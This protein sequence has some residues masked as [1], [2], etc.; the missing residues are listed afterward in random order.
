M[1]VLEALTLLRFLDQTGS[2]SLALLHGPLIN[3]FVQYDDEEP[4]FLPRMSPAFLKERL[5]ISK[6]M[7]ASVVREFPE[8]MLWCHFMSTYCYAINRLYSYVTPIVGVVERATGCRLTLSILDHLKERHIIKES[9]VDRFKEELDKYDITD[10]VLFG[11]MLD[12]GEYPTPIRLQKNPYHR[13]RAKWQPLVRKYPEVN[14]I[15]L[16]TSPTQFP[17]RGRA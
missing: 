11:C 13:A 6:E 12:E 7:V 8:E 10:E 3:Q 15:I 2:Q 1:Y 14:A 5:G 16:K 4:N 17:F 9:Y